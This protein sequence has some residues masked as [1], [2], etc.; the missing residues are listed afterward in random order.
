M[1]TTIIRSS[2]FAAI[3]ILPLFL[4]PARDSSG[5]ASSFGTATAMADGKINRL[6]RW[7]GFGWSSGY[8]ACNS[9]GWSWSD[10]LPPV[11]NTARMHSSAGAGKFEL[12][13]PVPAVVHPVG[14]VVPGHHHGT[15]VQQKPIDAALW[16]SAPLGN[17]GGSLVIP[18]RNLPDGSF[19]P[20]RSAIPPKAPAI[21][22]EEAGAASPSDLESLPSPK[23]EQ[24]KLDDL[25]E[26]D[27]AQLLSPR[28]RSARQRGEPN[29]R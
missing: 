7:T 5:F 12:V 10:S 29:I 22:S 6:F 13:D 23:G 3:F 15:F 17:L 27:S 24:D 26:E 28:N 14:H 21:D 4:T 9:N 20:Y 18:E 1:R 16:Q 2:T 8:H 11:G 25:F 19:Q